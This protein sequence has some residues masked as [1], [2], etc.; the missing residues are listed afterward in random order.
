[1]L[2]LFLFIPLA[3]EVVFYCFMLA[4]RDP[5]KCLIAKT[6]CSVTF[7]IIG[8][9]FFLRGEKGLTQWFIMGGLV[10]GALGDIVLDIGN[11]HKDSYKK[12]FVCGGVSFLLGHFAYIVTLFIALTQQRQ[13][14]D[15]GLLHL[16]DIIRDTT[17]PFLIGVMI[18]LL[19]AISIYSTIPE[20]NAETYFKIA[21]CA[22]LIIVS[23]AA[24]L[25]SSFILVISFR[26][27][28]MYSVGFILFLISDSTLMTNMFGSGQTIKKDCIIIPTYYLA[29]FAFALVL[30]IPTL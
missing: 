20:I 14:F 10:L 15:G 9:I 25:A 22:Y 1:M 17:L 5:K 30:Y 6:I 3:A 27:F 18:V 28:I 7:V 2:A 29:Q 19:I 12:Y 13:S 26:T 24:G 8:L 4:K 16:E 11:F 23:I 21:I